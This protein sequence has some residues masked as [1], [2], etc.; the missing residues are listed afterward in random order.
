MSGANKKVGAEEVFGRAV[1]DF[2]QLHR[3]E[4]IVVR[5]EDFADDI[6]P[7]DYLFR[8][9]AEMP[10]IEQMALN[11]ASGKILDVGACAGSHSLALQNRGAEV[12]ALDLS[13]KAIKT[14]QKRGVQKTR[15]ADFFELGHQSFDTLL[16]LMN[17]TGIAGRFS[18]LPQFFNQLKNLLSGDGQVLI[19]SSDLR[20]L[21]AEEELVDFYDRQVY[22]GDFRYSIHYKNLDSTT[23]NWLYL[24]FQTL[25]AAA[26]QYGFKTELLAET[27]DHAF[28][29]RLSIK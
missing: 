15:T 28:L 22:F 12:T 10:E 2:E 11:K 27:N 3:A 25:S 13:E 23:F 26:G 20:Y 8:E 21:Y 14:C 24:D 29:A 5:A 19:D 6:I 18:N 9:Y 7:V 17:G 16:M 1:R 4:D